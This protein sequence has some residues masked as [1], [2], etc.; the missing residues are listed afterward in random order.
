[1]QTANWQPH[2]DL[3]SFAAADVGR[4]Q[5][6]S[7]SDM[8]RHW[9]MTPTAWT[10][11]DRKGGRGDSHA[12]K[13]TPRGDPDNESDV[14]YHESYDSNINPLNE[15]EITKVEILKFN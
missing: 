10:R 5:P 15:D 4:K 13:V 6:S 2:T 3:P 9:R 8:D 1:M 14:C 11:E 7:S 12:I